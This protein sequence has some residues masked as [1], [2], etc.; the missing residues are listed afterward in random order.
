MTPEESNYQQ[1]LEEQ[2]RKH[3]SAARYRRGLLLIAGAFVLLG[4]WLKVSQPR[5][6][7][8]P[9]YKKP[10]VVFIRKKLLHQDYVVRC[11]W[12]QDEHGTWG[13]CAKN[14]QGKWFIFACDDVWQAMNDYPTV[15][16]NDE[17]PHETNTIVNE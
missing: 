11:T 8:V 10:E 13:W 6:L 5:C 15:L 3:E 4:G 2:I 14:H 12:Q 16:T 1:Q 9:N 7:W 17:F